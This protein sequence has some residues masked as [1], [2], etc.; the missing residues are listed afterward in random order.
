MSNTVTVVFRQHSQWKLVLIPWVQIFIIIIRVILSISMENKH[1]IK[2]MSTSVRNTFKKK[3][4]KTIV[5]IY[6]NNN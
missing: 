4:K 2:H 5:T 6:E 1:S 3:T